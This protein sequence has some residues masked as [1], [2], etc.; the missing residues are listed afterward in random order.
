MV[1]REKKKRLTVN[2]L[3]TVFKCRMD[4]AGMDWFLSIISQTE[5]K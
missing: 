5:A 3:I 4:W 1:W 2:V